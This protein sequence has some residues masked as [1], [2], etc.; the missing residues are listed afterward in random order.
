[1]WHKQ[2]SVL[3]QETQIYIIK[4]ENQYFLECKGKIWATY[5]NVLILVQTAYGFDLKNAEN[6]FKRS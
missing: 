4:K 2:N 1:M 3:E 5:H 6:N